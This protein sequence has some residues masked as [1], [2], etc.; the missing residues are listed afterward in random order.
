MKKVLVI[1]VL[2]ACIIGFS[3]GWVLMLMVNQ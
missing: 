2:V 3:C 1:V